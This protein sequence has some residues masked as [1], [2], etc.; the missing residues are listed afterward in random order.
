[1]SYRSFLLLLL[2]IFAVLVLNID[3]QQAIL[4]YLDRLQELSEYNIDGWQ[5]MQVQTFYLHNQNK[6]PVKR[7]RRRVRK[8]F[9]A[10]RYQLRQEWE[11]NYNLEWPK[12]EVERSRM[13]TLLYEAHHI[14]PINAGGINQWWNITPLS[15][16]NHKLL[17]GT[18]EEKACFSHDIVRQRFIRFVLAAKVMG[19]KCVAYGEECIAQIKQSVM[20]SREDLREAF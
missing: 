7:E 17:H 6:N 9:N 19:R 5:R 10:Q 20:F 4:L 12:V 2:T 16:E 8:E 15:S 13:K 14:I 1:M 11:M 3:D 18:L